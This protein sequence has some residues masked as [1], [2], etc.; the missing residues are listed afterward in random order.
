MFVLFLQDLQVAFFL[1]S[2]TPLA[3]PAPVPTGEGGVFSFGRQDSVSTVTEPMP[4]PLSRVQLSGN[5]LGIPDAERK[6]SIATL[7]DEVLIPTTSQPI[8]E[9]VSYNNQ[10]STLLIDAYICAGVHGDLQDLSP[11]N[12]CTSTCT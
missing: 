9:E 10:I 5:V 3:S 12:T 4:P 11:Y 1:D 2:S 6:G 8:I 7:K